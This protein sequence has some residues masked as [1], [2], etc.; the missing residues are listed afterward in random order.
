MQL[1]HTELGMAADAKQAPRAE[2][3]GSSEPADQDDSIP[4]FPE[5]AWRASFKDY[6]DAMDGSTEASDVVHFATLWAATAVAAGRRVSYYAGDCI[7]PNVFLNYYGPTGDK[8]TTAERRLFQC[9]LV[10]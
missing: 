1:R 2:K 9:G 4:A 8:K 7:Y 3:S 5:L 6:R 10:N